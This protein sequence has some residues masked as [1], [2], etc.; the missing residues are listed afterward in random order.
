MPYRPMTDEE[1]KRTE[2]LITYLK[3]KMDVIS[4]NISD[5]EQY[6]EQGNWYMTEED[7]AAAWAWAREIAEA[8]N[9]RRAENEKKRI[10]EEKIANNERGKNTYTDVNIERSETDSRQRMLL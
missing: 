6:I 1:R 9:K 7:S 2:D 3:K 4:K 10:E 8:D 5:L